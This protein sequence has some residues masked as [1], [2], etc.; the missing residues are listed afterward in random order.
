MRLNFLF[1]SILFLSIVNGEERY[2][3]RIYIAPDV[4]Y[5]NYHEVLPPPQKSDEHGTLGGFQLGYDYVE[6]NQLYVGGNW[7][8]VAGNTTYDGSILNLETMKVSPFLS[9]T[10]NLLTNLEGRIGYTFASSPTSRFYI[11]VFTGIG[12]NYWRRDVGYLEL[13]SWEYIIFGI[14]PAYRFSPFF[15]LGLNAELMPMF[16]G[17]IQINMPFSGWVNLQLGNKLQYSFE[18]PIRFIF[19]KTYHFDIALVPFYRNQ[20]LGRSNMKI[21]KVK[22]VGQVT[23]HEPSSDCYVV[24]GRIEAG[25]RF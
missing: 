6:N 22:G 12:W 19:P 21:L 2:P 1:L 17:T 10:G 15:E 16:Y 18:L 9:T 14:R 8:L 20:D 25:Y 13:Y 11:P 24:G 7:E 5:R 4:Y 3:N 23:I